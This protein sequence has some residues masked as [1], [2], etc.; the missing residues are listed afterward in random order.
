MA[1]RGLLI[2]FVLAALILGGLILLFGPRATADALRSFQP[3]EAVVVILLATSWLA[4][5]AEA[6]YQTVQVSLPEITR[7]DCLTAFLSG[8]FVASIFPVGNVGGVV[9][10]AYVLKENA[11]VPGSTTVGVLSAW[12][13]L[14]MI[15]SMSVAVVGILVVL[16]PGGRVDPAVLT[17]VGIF[18]T[19]VVVTMILWQFR[20]SWLTTLS[21][22]AARLLHA[23]VVRIAPTTAE[24]F[25]PTI[26]AARG[27]RFTAGFTTLTSRP[28]VLGQT[29]LVLVLAW[30]ALG[31]ALLVSF[32]S[33]GSELPIGVAL[34]VPQVAGLAGI[35]P[36]PGGLGSIDAT[37]VALLVSLTSEHLDTIGAAVLVFRVA[38]YWW[39]LLV[40]TIVVMGLGIS[41]R[42]TVSPGRR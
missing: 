9:S 7:W 35:I 15:A 13:V 27:R 42:N 34:L 5:R 40:S 21:W 36:L 6:M 3:M 17:L 32:R 22:H 11:G 38:T 30:T 25:A 12:E 39:G 33:L 41:V 31:A 28:R 18:A 20:R 4:L 37:L 2:R 19:I 16:L 23:V 26:L 8:V 24:R 14:N 1:R 10:A 29:V